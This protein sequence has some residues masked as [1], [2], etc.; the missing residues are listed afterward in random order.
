MK[1]VYFI[2]ISGVLIFGITAV[3]FLSCDSQ[4]SEKE[5][6]KEEPDKFDKTEINLIR[7]EDVIKQKYD[8]KITEFYDDGQALTAEYYDKE[9]PS[10]PVFMRK[11]YR[12]GK[13]FIEGP[14]ENGKR[15]GKW[16]AW[17][18]NGNIWS[19]GN[20]YNGLEH[21]ASKVFYENSQIRYNKEHDM[22]IPHGLWK[23]YC[24]EGNLLGEIMYEQ[25]EIEWENNYM[26]LS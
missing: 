15:H 11:Y 6:T 21:G 10:E 22:G 19:T 9:N 2:F 4:I 13:N 7:G 5:I 16:I 23:F 12:S 3:L 25:G 20:Y 14:L 24:P 17:F 26:E 8:E 1:Q 18:E